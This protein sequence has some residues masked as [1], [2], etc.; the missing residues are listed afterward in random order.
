MAKISTATFMNRL[1]SRFRSFFILVAATMMWPSVGDTRDLDLSVPEDALLASHRIACGTQKP[2]HYEYGVWRG[3]VFGRVAWEVDR[4]L[5]DV[6]GVNTRRCPTVVDPE[7]GTGY[8]LVSRE[9][10]FFLEPGTENILEDWQNPYTGKDV[11]VLPV[12]ND[13]VNFPP[14]LPYKRDG[15]PYV[16]PGEV[17]GDTVVRNVQAKFYFPNS[18]G[19]GFDKAMGGFSQGMEVYTHFIPKAELLT[20]DE[21]IVQSSR[22]AWYR[23]ADWEPWMEMGDIPGN[24]IFSTY[25]WRVKTINAL[26]QIL[27]DAMNTN[28]FSLYREPPPED[29]TRPMMDGNNVYREFLAGQGQ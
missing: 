16:F 24:L 18:L 13:P 14:V 8:R 15:S 17:I 25:G 21:T 29:D 6:V 12:K 11:T 9:F 10:M 23:F 27:Q 7:R 19:G 28:A 26:P 3:K 20:D 5:F 4:H 1:R 22:L 2:G